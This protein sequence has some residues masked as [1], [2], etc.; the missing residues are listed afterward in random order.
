MK[1]RLTQVE[2][3]AVEAGVRRVC[4]GLPCLRTRVWEVEDTAN[5]AKPR[6]EEIAGRLVVPCPPSVPVAVLGCTR[7]S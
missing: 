4:N 7:P 1:L 6:H 3:M 2:S 5:R